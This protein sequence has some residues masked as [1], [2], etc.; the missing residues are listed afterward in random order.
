MM[1]F[2]ISFVPTTPCLSYHLVF[3]IVIMK[4]KV[5]SSPD[6]SILSK[7]HPDKSRIVKDARKEL[8]TFAADALDKLKSSANIDDCSVRIRLGSYSRGLLKLEE[9]ASKAQKDA[10]KNKKIL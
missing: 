1:G 9:E 8:H 7:I 4:S 2:L 5:T 3:V 6:K 10:A